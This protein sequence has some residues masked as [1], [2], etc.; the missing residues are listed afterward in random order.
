MFGHD[1]EDLM[2]VVEIIGPG[3]PTSEELIDKGWR[4]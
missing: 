2:R 1:G 3:Q 4:W